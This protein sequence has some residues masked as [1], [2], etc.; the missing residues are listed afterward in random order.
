MSDALSVIHSRKSVRKY[1]DRPI[2]R[3]TLET[4]CRA[5]MAAPSAGNKKPWAFVVITRRETLV[6]LAQG[7]QYG[8]MVQGAAAAIVVCG[9]MDRA[10]PGEE[11]DFWIQDCSA[12]S[13]NLL[14]AAEALGLGAVWGGVYPMADRV[15]K[16][17]AI[18]GLPS[19]VVPL[20][21]LALGYPLGGEKAKDKFDPACIRW[22]K[23]QGT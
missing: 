6:S 11:R 21:I 1:Q 18:L 23:W 10:L 13:E 2:V 19:D 20:N 17:R 8:K 14:L 22:E 12:A 9:L 15:A 16:V 3:E 5:A 7:L 4:L